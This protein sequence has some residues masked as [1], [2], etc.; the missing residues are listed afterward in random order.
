MSIEER[1]RDS[2]VC[3]NFDVISSSLVTEQ[4]ILSGD[5]SFLEIKRI[6]E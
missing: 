1:S 6:S 2:S 5:D 4:L 3:L